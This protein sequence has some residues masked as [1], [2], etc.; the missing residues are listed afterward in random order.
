MVMWLICNT[1]ESGGDTNFMKR[2]NAYDIAN[3]FMKDM[4][5]DL[6]DGNGEKPPTFIE[7]IWECELSKYADLNISMG[8][9]EEEGCCIHRCEIVDKR[10]DTVIEMLSGYG[11]DSVEN[12][13]DTILDLCR[14]YE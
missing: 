5:P 12:L 6:W 13:T 1:K 9:C 4:N 7:L 11:I 14:N 2:E 3:S 10:G 8:Y